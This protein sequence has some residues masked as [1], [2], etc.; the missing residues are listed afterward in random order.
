MIFQSKLVKAWLSL[1]CI[2]QS[3]ASFLSGG[4]TT[5]AVV[6]PPERIL[7]KRTSVQWCKLS[8]LQLPVNP[9]ISFHFYFST[10][11]ANWLVLQLHT[12]PQPKLGSS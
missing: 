6:N 5:M 1:Q 9:G 2:K 11:E 3:F 4:F 8:K 10:K 12:G 7:A